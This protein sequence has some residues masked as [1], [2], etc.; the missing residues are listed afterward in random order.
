LIGPILRLTIRVL[1]ARSKKKLLSSNGFPWS[2]A[3]VPP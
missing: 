2:G 1:A 3:V